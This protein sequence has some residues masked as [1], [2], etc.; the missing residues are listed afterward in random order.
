VNKEYVLIIGASSAIGREIIRQIA[1]A[2]MVILAHYNTNATCLAELAKE[3]PAAVIPIQA[4]LQSETSIDKMLTIIAG[5]CPFPDKLVFLAA[6]KL[7]LARFK[8]MTWDDFQTQVDVQLRPIVLI[9]SRFLPKMAASKA[10]KLVFV[11]TSATL[12]VPP[13]AMAPYVTAKYALLGFMKSLASEYASKT[14]C[15][16]A[17]SPSMVETEFLTSIPQK[18]VELTAD[19]HPRKRN[20]TPRDVA[21][22]VKFLLSDEANFVTGANIPI[23]GGCA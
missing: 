1:H 16:N 7:L 19:Q 4:D 13:A 6:P 8:D 10:G 3:I 2:N 15:I 18:L 21:P 5:Q 12:G 23:T 11:L 9:C 22:L 20:A 14:I 17:V